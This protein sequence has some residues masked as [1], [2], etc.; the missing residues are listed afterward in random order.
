MFETAKIITN[1]RF[2]AC[3]PQNVFHRE[4]EPMPEG[5]VHDKSLCN[6]HV[7][8]RRSFVLA[9]APGKALI[10][11]TAD[12]YYKLYINGVFVT[13]GP[14]AGYPQHYYYNTVDVTEYLHEGENLI[15][16]HTYYQGL[17]NRVWVSADM[18]HMMLCQ[19]DVDGKTAL[20]SDESWK[21]AEHTGYSASHTF[22]YETQY[23]EDFDS[24]AAEV[25]FEKPSFDDSA[26]EYAKE[27]LHTDYTFALQPTKQLEIYD[28]PP[29]RI[30]RRCEDGKTVL[31][32][33]LGFEAVGAVCLR[34][35]GL[36]GSVVVIRCGEEC[37]TD[38][39]G[40]DLDAVRYQMRCN[41]VYEETWTLSG[42]D[43]VLV[44]YDYKAFRYFELHLPKGC[45]MKD[46]DV[47]FQ[48]RHYPY[49]E[50]VSCP[51]DDP[52]LQKI[53]RLCA[54]TL[55]YGAQEGFMD[56]PTREK[57]QYLN[58]C[59]V[60]ACAYTL[61]TGDAALMK[62]AL[63]DYAR[64]AFITPGLMTCAPGALMQEIADATMQFPMQ[65]LFCYRQ[66]GDRKLLSDLLPVCEA[67]AEHFRKFDRGDGLLE[68]V[69][70]WNLIDWPE[71]LRDDYDFPATKPIGPGAHNVMNAFGYGMQ[72]E[73][74]KIRA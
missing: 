38:E 48:V 60:S 73:I 9:K 10:S 50:A 34:A 56:C 40:A 16:V 20:V 42:G 8:F 31:F 74:D 57:G 4:I 2:S 1:A 44:P 5:Y 51:S 45:E 26:W 46:E 28:V 25:G 18:R 67:A 17:I 49:K 47:V 41:C 33:D 36:P 35:K 37:L 69:D 23:A 15:A 7:L 68:L 66:S 64:S 22:G 55:K 71:N 12:D 3:V 62:K 29:A 30:T 72:R 27:R 6:R 63:Y 11:I 70:S 43:D 54:D 32:C 59:S 52:E 13:Q 14:A 65:V 19:L 39:N 53:W 61:L 24:R 58:D 21:C